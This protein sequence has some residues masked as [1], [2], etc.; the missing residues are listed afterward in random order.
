[1][2]LNLELKVKIRSHDEV[3]TLL[4][5]IKCEITNT[6]TQKDTYYKYPKG[7]LKLREQNGKFQL[8]KYQRNG[9]ST[10][11]WSDY[12]ILHL[13]GDNVEK[14]LEELFEVETIVKKVRNLYIYKNTR[15]HLDEVKKLGKYLELETV[16]EEITQEEAKQQFEDVIN[17][18]NLESLTGIRNSYKDLVLK[19]KVN[20]QMNNT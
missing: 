17:L 7:L 14:Y 4:N 18:L 5:S 1:M 3:I 13:S 12:S 8:V 19:N 15:I 6:L 9:R 11:R 10:E 16:V 20:K 2:A